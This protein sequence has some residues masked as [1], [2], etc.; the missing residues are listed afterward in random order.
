MDTSNILK[1]LVSIT[2]FNKGQAAK[3]F[4][5]LKTERRIIV[6]KNNAPSAILLSPDEYLRLLEIEEDSYLL[7]LAEQRLADYNTGDG[8]PYEKAL[9]QMG[10]TH[11]DIENA[12]DVEIE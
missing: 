6:L 5:R 8:I 12:E 11:E 10:L 1:S 2:Q 7:N 4:D 3:I 9:V